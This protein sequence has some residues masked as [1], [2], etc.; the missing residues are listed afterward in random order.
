MPAICRFFICHRSPAIRI[1]DYHMGDSCMSEEL[2][3]ENL[4]DDELLNLV[5]DEPLP[6]DVDDD[7]DSS[8]AESSTAEVDEADGEPD[9]EG[10]E[11]ADS[12]KEA[13]PEEQ[14]DVD[15]DLP[16][17][18]KNGKGTI[19]YSVLQSTREQ[20][21]TYKQESEASAKKVAEL[22]AKVSELSDKDKK[23]SDV[24]V[25]E[26]LDMSAEDLEL[27]EEDNPEL[28]SKVKEAVK[29]AEIYK[30]KTQEL[31]DKEKQLEQQ[32]QAVEIQSAIDSVPKLAYIQ[33]S[34]PE[35]FSFAS[36]IDAKF[37]E[38]GEHA[39]LTMAERFEK[40]IEHIET[41]VI[42]AEI[43]LPHTATKKQ[44]EVKKATEI[45]SLDDIPGGQPP[46]ANELEAKL[47][48]PAQELL[49]DME[50]MTQEQLDDFM[51]RL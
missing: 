51:A 8:D 26:I 39:D 1:C 5:A 23:Y 50:N 49:A 30:H 47:A 16:V 36:M 18:T 12:D 4:T 7:N 33:S 13:Q 45:K 24:D 21:N 29:A 6:D 3:L 34:N 28:A 44:I 17:E 15:D 40:V 10:G 2:D 9:A 43:Q 14:E 46:V 22:E 42:G 35:L 20:V 31:T 19:P 11:T 38:S 25:N 27:L 48:K 41:K 37:N 32:K